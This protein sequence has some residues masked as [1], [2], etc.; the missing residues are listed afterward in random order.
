L[1]ELN[2]CFTRHETCFRVTALASFRAH[3]LAV[4]GFVFLTAMCSGGEADPEAP[5]ADAGPDR[6]AAGAVGKTCFPLG[7]SQ[8]CS[9]TT[10]RAGQKRCLQSGYFGPCE[11]KGDTCEGNDVSQCVAPYSRCED[12]QTLRYYVRPSCQSGRCTWETTLYTCPLQCNYGGCTGISTMAGFPSD[13]ANTYPPANDAARSDAND[14]ARS[15][16][17]DAAEQ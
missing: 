17:N 12:S 5:S 3:P 6:G 7:V 8:S 16:A 13:A 14:A 15:D 10:G 9:C 4:L 2:A 1:R 11:C